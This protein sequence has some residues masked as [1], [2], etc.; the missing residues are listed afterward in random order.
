MRDNED[1]LAAAKREFAEETGLTPSGDFIPLGEI[2]Q[3]GG[4]VVS[5][6][7]AGRRLRHH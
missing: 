1:P 2:R 5:V 7:G 4:K 6:V 3:P